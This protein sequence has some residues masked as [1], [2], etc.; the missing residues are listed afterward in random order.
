MYQLQPEKSKAKLFKLKLNKL[1]IKFY[2]IV[3]LALNV[4]PILQ[5]TF[6]YSTCLYLILEKH[7]F[8][9]LPFFRLSFMFLTLSLSFNMSKQTVSNNPLPFFFFFFVQLKQNTLTTLYLISNSIQSVT[10]HSH[11]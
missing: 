6:I 1:F 4:F 11:F 2:T 7:F 8:F 3:L 10:P 5:H 9:G